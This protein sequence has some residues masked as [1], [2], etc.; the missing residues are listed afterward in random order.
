MRELLCVEWDLTGFAGRRLMERLAVRRSD[1]LAA[2]DNSPEADQRGP[3]SEQLPLDLRD[4]RP[5]RK[6]RRPYRVRP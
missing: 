3:I 6:N 5:A 1:R 4:D 2:N